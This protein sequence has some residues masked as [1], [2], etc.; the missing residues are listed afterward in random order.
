[1]DVKVHSKEKYK[2]L[3]ETVDVKEFTDRDLERMA[4][5]AEHGVKW[6]DIFGIGG[7]QG[8]DIIVQDSIA[9]KSVRSK[10]PVAIIRQSNE[11]YT[12]NSVTLQPFT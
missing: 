5:L 7:C 12:K 3:Y 9:R 1:M 6:D 11:E 10:A 8:S 4:Y 2:R